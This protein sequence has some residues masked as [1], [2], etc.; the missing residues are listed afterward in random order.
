VNWALD[1]LSHQAN[2]DYN[3]KTRLKL[4]S[5]TCQDR[6]LTFV[7]RPIAITSSIIICVLFQLILDFEVEEFRENRSRLPPMV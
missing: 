2:P 1:A 6:S 3:Q 4:K 5:L 7:S